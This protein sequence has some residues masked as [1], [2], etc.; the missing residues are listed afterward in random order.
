M[1][2]LN[3]DNFVTAATL[4]KFLGTAIPIVLVA[5]LILFVILSIVLNYHWKKYSAS[6]VLYLKL[7]FSYLV[8][9]IVFEALMIFAQAL[10]YQ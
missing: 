2:F 4:P 6:P 7:R 3:F 9:G 10:Y 8:G 1:D 5:M